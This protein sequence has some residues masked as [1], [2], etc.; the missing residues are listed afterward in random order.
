L[1]QIASSRHRRTF[2]QSRGATAGSGL[3]LCV[4]D[5]LLQVCV[6][7]A[8]QGVKSRFAGQ[9]RKNASMISRQTSSPRGFLVPRPRF[10]KR[11]LYWPTSCSVMCQRLLRGSKKASVCYKEAEDLLLLSTTTRNGSS[12]RLLLRKCRMTQARHA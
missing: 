11:W 5:D 8:T 1:R 9:P 6:V 12:S 10:F 4:K 2:R 3:R 7:L